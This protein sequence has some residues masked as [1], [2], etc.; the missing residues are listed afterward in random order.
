MNTYFQPQQADYVTESTYGKFEMSRKEEHNMDQAVQH[1][2][3]N[4][5]HLS[6]KVSHV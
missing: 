6:E 3:G 5:R 4:T 1:G 2:V